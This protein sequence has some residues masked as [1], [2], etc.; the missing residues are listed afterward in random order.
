VDELASA[1]V[2]LRLVTD[3]GILNLISTTTLF[4]TPLDITLTGIAIES[5]FPADA[6]TSEALHRLGKAPENTVGAGFAKLT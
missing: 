2:P 6:A 3:G 5:F 1:V 4:G